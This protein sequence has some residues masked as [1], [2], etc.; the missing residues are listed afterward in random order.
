MRRV[1]SVP[2]RQAFRVV[3]WLAVSIATFLLWLA[4]AGQVL[5]AEPA[6]VPLRLTVHVAPGHAQFTAAYPELL[7][8]QLPSMVRVRIAN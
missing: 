2:V 4:M 6:S 7:R 5:A 8:R 3:A 1:I